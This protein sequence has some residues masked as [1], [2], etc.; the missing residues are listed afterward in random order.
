[1]FQV[2]LELGIDEELILTWPRDKFERWVAFLR[3]RD[4]RLKKAGARR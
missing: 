4:E 1:M 2:A 3:L